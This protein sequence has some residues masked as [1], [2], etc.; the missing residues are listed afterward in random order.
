MFNR[1]KRQMSF[2]FIDNKNPE[3]LENNWKKSKA[4]NRPH[5]THKLSLIYLRKH[6]I[7]S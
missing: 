4:E 5:K 2:N 1:F 7:M 3:S 6:G